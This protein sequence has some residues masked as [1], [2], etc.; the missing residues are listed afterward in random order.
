MVFSPF[1]EYQQPGEGSRQKSIANLTTIS[2]NGGFC[3]GAERKRRYHP[4]FCFAVARS[5]ELC[6]NKPIK[7][8]E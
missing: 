4:R 3:N 8:K 5:W 7:G 1:R 2:K 6:Y